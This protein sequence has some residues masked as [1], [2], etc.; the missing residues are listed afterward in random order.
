[1]SQLLHKMLVKL[2]GCI[3]RFVTFALKGVSK[4][5]LKGCKY[6]RYNERSEYSPEGNE[7][8]VQ[9]NIVEFFI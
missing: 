8:N 5:V 4:G 6:T 1:M 3:T 9:I 7:L 2:L